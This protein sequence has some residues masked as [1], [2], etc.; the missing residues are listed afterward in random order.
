MLKTLAIENLA[1]ID[2]LETAFDA[3]LSVL[4]GETGAGKS[5]LVDAIELALGK[6]AQTR[7]IRPGARRL[8]ISLVFDVGD[9]PQAGAWLERREL[10]Q[11]DDSCILRRTVGADGRS[12]AWI[13]G[14]PATLEQLR[15][16]ASHLIDIVGQNAHQML[17]RR[18]KHLYLLDSQCGHAEQLREIGQLA[19][20]W[21]EAGETLEQL[22]ENARELTERREWLERQVAELEG[23]GVKPGEYGE[24]EREHRLL[25]KKESLKSAL[26]EVHAM[27]DDNDGADAATLLGRAS[28]VVDKLRDT[29]PQLAAAG[30]LVA[31]ALGQTGEAAREIR[32]ALER[33]EVSDE[34]FAQLEQRISRLSALADKYRTQPAALPEQLEYART[35]LEKLG[36]PATDPEQL[37]RERAELEKRYGELAAGV[38]ERRRKTAAALEKN[39]VA[40]L[41]KLNL[42]KAEFKV[43]FAGAGDDAPSPAGRERAEFM[44]RANPGQDLQPLTATASGGELSR[45]SLALQ[46]ALSK[47]RPMPVLI[48][49]EV[50]SGVGGATAGTVGRLLQAI[51]RRAQVFC[52]TH[53]PQVAS[54]AAHHYRV[55]KEQDAHTRVQLEKLDGRERRVEIARMMAGEKITKQSL[56]HARQMLGDGEMAADSPLP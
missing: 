35:E 11:A 39:V 43:R 52:I 45:I 26:H 8:S 18:D 36:D 51:S 42:A 49:D 13:N 21:K 23:S 56:E 15:E 4:T 40:T 17:L 55:V 14:Q 28:G 38:S 44:I 27:L 25:S 47:K 6:R 3:G 1:I 48:F 24:L 32:G 31:A 41:H 34:Y 9:I 46:M 33:I 2:R 7:L 54:R 16:L 29:D 22:A 50:D 53:L 10:A 5:I 30:E 37:R 12:Q 19:R 20:R